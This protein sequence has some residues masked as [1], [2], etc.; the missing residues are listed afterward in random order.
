VP[1][2]A[3]AFPN[4]RV[5]PGRRFIDNG[6]VITTAGVS[7][8]IDGALHLVAKTLGRYIA[9]RTAEY[10]EY[11]WSPQSY[12]TSKYPL[13]NPRLDDTGRKFQQA[14]IAQ[15]EGD[16]DGAIA[17]YRAVLAAKPD[18]R[19]AWLQLGRTLHGLKRYAEAATA[20]AEAAKGEAQRPVALYNLTCA[21]ALS[22]EREKALDAAQKAFDAGF[23]T[24][25]YW[26]SDQDLASIRE[27][28]RFKALLAK[29]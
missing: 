22:G 23:R 13:L 21:Y 2:L 16:T 7:A 8:G 5:Q 20:H 10:M 3:K 4:A 15:Q 6:K 26:E 14:S 18:N 25:Y 29:L 19:E 17:I 28:P 1:D 24:K 9:D 11:A 12:T 27:D